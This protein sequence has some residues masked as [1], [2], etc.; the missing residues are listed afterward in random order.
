MSTNRTLAELR[1]DVFSALGFIDPFTIPPVKT[2]ATL[3]AEIKSQLGLATPM[4]TYPTKTLAQLRTDLMAKLGFAVQAASPPPGMAALLLSFVNQAQNTLWRR[5]E[6]DRGGVAFPTELTADANPTTIDGQAVL[7]LAIALGK[8]HLGHPDAKAYM[9]ESERWLADELQRN[10][11]NI[12]AMINTLLA[13]AQQVAYRQYE[14]ARGSTFSIGAFA[15]DGDET[16][17]DYLPVFLLALA[18]VKAR[19]KQTDA[20]LY[21]DQYNRYMADLEKRMPA[22]AG[23]VVTQMLRSAQRDLYRRYKVLRTER[24]FTWTCVAGQNLYELNENDEQTAPTPCLEVIDPREITWAGIERDGRWYPLICGIPPEVYSRNE[25]SAWPTRYEI[26]QCIELWPSPGLDV[27]TLRLK[28]HSELGAF[29]AEDDM[30]TIDDEP[31]YLLAVANAKAYYRQPDAQN[32]IG[33]LEA[34]IRNVVAGAHQTRRYVPGEKVRGE[35]YIEP[36]PTV[37]F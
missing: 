34:Y 33:Q 21:E 22:N 12:D 23:A 14:M 16:T 7:T 35:N 28:G 29:A 9:E 1:T 5:L 3:R 13:E 19:L 11:P 8:A 25:W 30:T 6:L 15:V 10:P 26:R 4:G 31:V 37:P 32:Y 36:R 18:N 24:M 17:I 27:Q 20:K 2:L